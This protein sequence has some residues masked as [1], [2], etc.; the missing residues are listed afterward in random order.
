MLL[1]WQYPAW[2]E[3][4]KGKVCQADYDKYSRQFE[5]MQR[6]CEEFE[7]ESDADTTE[8]KQEKFEKILDLMQQVNS[9]F[10]KFECCFKSK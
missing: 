10:L 7:N 8:Q 3:E 4:N 9:D 6:V 1:Y 2:L 5:L